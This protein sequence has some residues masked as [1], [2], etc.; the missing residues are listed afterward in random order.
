LSDGAP[1]KTHVLSLLHRLVDEKSSAPQTVDAP[2]ALSLASEPR[3]A[4]LTLDKSTAK[5]YFYE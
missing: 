4:S 2:Q 3:A 1:T 5:P